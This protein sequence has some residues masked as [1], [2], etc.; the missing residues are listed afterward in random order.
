MQPIRS[1][2]S[3]MHPHMC[4][5]GLS[6]QIQPQASEWHL[7]CCLLTRLLFQTAAA[8][9]S[10]RGCSGNTEWSTSRQTQNELSESWRF[11]DGRAVCC[12]SVALYASG[13]ALFG[14]L[15]VDLTHTFP[16][17]VCKVPLTS[18]FGTLTG[19]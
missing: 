2:Y 4:Y 11:F 18:T 14:Q 5:A 16:W 17:S 13:I 6:A 9:F 7:Q 8:L 10:S 3:S 12:D 15:A 1:S 19:S